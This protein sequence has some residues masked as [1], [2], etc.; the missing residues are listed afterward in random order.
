MLMMIAFCVLGTLCVVSHVKVLIVIFFTD[1]KRCQEY[2]EKQIENNP[3]PVV[4]A[5]TAPVK[6]KS[7]QRTKGAGKSLAVRISHV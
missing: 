1:L 2:K 4:E 7:N 6:L 3:L 5:K